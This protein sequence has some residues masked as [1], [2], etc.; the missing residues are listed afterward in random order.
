MEQG[1]FSLQLR[2]RSS[3]HGASAPGPWVPGRLEFHVVQNNSKHTQRLRGAAAEL[4][5]ELTL[6]ASSFPK[7]LRACRTRNAFRP[8][9]ITEFLMQFSAKFTVDVQQTSNFCLKNAVGN[10]GMH[11]INHSAGNRF[12]AM[13]ERRTQQKTAG[14]RS[15]TQLG[16]FLVEFPNS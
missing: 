16:A 11:P 15:H 8:C 9:P 5:M 1:F 12:E 3:H 10:V 13:P 6:S 7:E 14:N 2:P 4:G